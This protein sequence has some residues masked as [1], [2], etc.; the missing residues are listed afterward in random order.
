M[1]SFYSELIVKSELLVKSGR[2][3]L[4]KMFCF[5]LWFFKRHLHNSNLANAI[6]NQF[7]NFEYNL[8]VFNDFSTSSAKV[9]IKILIQKQISV[10]LS[11]ESVGALQYVLIIVKISLGCKINKSAQGWVFFYVINYIKE[12]S[13]L[14]FHDIYFINILILELM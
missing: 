9:A 1:V 6:A 10:K 2:L 14:L 3:A 5:N 12:N 8:V 4:S 11:Q 7:C 13:I